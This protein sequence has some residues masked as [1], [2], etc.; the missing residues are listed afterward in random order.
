MKYKF[1]IFLAA[2]LLFSTESNAQKVALKT[3]LLYDATATINL[4]A[5]FGLAPR[6]TL[7]ISGNYNG[8][9]FSHERRWKNWI[10]QPEAR[11]WLCERFGGHF[12]GL[13]LHGGMYNMSNIKN[14]LNFLGSDFSPLTSK[15]YQGW[16]VGAGL[17]YGYSWILSKH[18]NF[19]AEVGAGYAYTR[20]ESYPC[21]T[22]GT[23]IEE[24][25]P[26]HYF[27]VTKLALSLVYLF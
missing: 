9:K 25:V 16:F 4:G 7:D 1:M 12:F 27:G 22:C 18:W 5:E 24:N 26:H 2:L 15:R 21:A 6:W 8:W 11:Y 10:V 19:E 20:Y 23:K 17:G 14:N 3:N 13:H